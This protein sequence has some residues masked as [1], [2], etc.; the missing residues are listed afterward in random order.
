MGTSQRNAWFDDFA[1]GL[2]AYYLTSLPVVLGLLFGADFIRARQGG[3]ATPS[4]DFLTACTR[5]DARNYLL[6]VRHGYAYDP[7]RRS[8][9][10]FFPAFPL[11]CRGLT[12]GSG[13]P[14]AAAALVVAN[15][16]LA[17][18]FVLMAGYLRTRWPGA[19]G[20][21]RALALAVFGLWPAGLFFRMPYAESLFLC[22]TL[23]VLYG[24]ARGW[25]LLPLAL[26]TGFVTATRP[27]GVALTAAFAWHLLTRPGESWGVRLARL[28]ALGP[29]ACWG[30]LAYMAYQAHAF[31]DPFAFART[32]EHWTM[33]PPRP[34]GWQDKAWSLLT[35]EP[36]WGVYLPG[37]PRYWGDVDLHGNAAFSLAFWN[38]FL[39]VGAA[40][41]LA[42]GAW[43]RWLNGAEVVLG[44]GLLAIPYLTRS[45][46]MSMAS[47]ARFA[48]VVVVNY[49][50]LGR[51]LG[52]APALLGGAVLATSAVLL[53]AWSALYAAEYLVF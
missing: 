14:P 11:L 36:V 32:Q 8:T 29:V 1:V 7:A 6:I 5:F 34:G 43:R 12:Q 48:A 37:G 2:A 52:R 19:S 40:V 38:P 10:A 28:A 44:G 30:L 16:A 47:H 9:V 22:G 49:L 3:P 35:L 42:L 26:L 33:L 18:A 23:A 31:G 4:P 17:G 21:Q 20:T 25:P 51:L 39:F 24:M 15:L 41:L 27:V 46:E 50:V 53:F 13:W 45:Y